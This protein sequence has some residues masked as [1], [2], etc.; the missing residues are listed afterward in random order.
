MYVYRNIYIYIC[1]LPTTA[2][3]MRR[4]LGLEVLVIEDAS[5]AELSARGHAVDKRNPA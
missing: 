3:A 5:K 4:G 2:T 1:I